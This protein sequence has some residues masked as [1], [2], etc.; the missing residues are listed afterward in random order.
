MGVSLD[1]DHFCRSHVISLAYLMSS[2]TFVEPSAPSE[3]LA[4]LYGIV[5]F[6]VKGN[7]TNLPVVIE[8]FKNNVKS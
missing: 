8:I 5:R 7:S 6:V 4:S 2:H 3:G 1:L